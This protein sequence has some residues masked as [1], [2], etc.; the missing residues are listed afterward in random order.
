VA[1]WGV[2]INSKGSLELKKRIIDEIP[3]FVHRS[4]IDPQI[5][6]SF[7]VNVPAT[8]PIIHLTANMPLAVDLEVGIN[9]GQP[10]F[11]YP[12]PDRLLPRGFFIKPLQDPTN[13]F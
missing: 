12:K 8:K 5:L 10:Y 4:V 13:Q 11:V 2:W 6:S 3:G 9:L 7:E 1:E